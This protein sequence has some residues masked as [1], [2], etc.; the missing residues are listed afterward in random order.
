MFLHPIG[1]QE[2]LI[3]MKQCE[4]KSST[5]EYTLTKKVISHIAKHHTHICNTSFKTGI[6]PDN[7]KVAKVIPVYKTSRKKKLFNKYMPIS[8]LLQF[9]KILKKLFDNRLKKFME[10]NKIKK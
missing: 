6:F 1:E 3:V 2:L 4:R 9:S 10:Q 5:T 7:M 8:L